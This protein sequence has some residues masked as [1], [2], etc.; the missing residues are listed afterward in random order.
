MSEVKDYEEVSIKRKRDRRS[1]SQV[2]AFLVTVY[3]PILFLTEKR[4]YQGSTTSLRIDDPLPLSKEL[5]SI[6]VV[7][8]QSRK[9]VESIIWTGY[10]TFDDNH[11][12]ASQA[13][14]LKQNILCRYRTE[15]LLMTAE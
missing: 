8:A 3:V 11:L 12:T 13:C 5:S 1:L 7:C 9:R 10:R 2:R 15:I 14:D 4:G 6:R